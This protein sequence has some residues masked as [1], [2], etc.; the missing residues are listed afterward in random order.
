MIFWFG[1]KKG[2]Y[3]KRFWHICILMAWCLFACSEN[4]TESE[5]APP[6]A[7]GSSQKLV[8]TLEGKVQESL[9]V[10]ARFNENTKVRLVELDDELSQTGSVANGSIDSA[11]N[12][13]VKTDGFT[14]RYA[15]LSVYGNLPFLC[16]DNQNFRLSMVVDLSTDSLANLDYFVHFASA[17]VKMLVKSDKMDFDKAREKAE[18]ETR[19]V[20]ALSAE[21]DNSVEQQAFSMF[22]EAA[23]YNSMDTELLALFDS[24]TNTFAST[25]KPARNDAFVSVAFTAFKAGPNL[26]EIYECPAIVSDSGSVNLPGETVASIQDY[27]QNLWMSILQEKE[28]TE[29]QKGEVH[30]FVES[31]GPANFWM[32]TENY[33]TCDGSWRFVNALEYLNETLTDEEDGKYK[34]FSFAES[35]SGYVYDE[36]SGWR[37]STLFESFFK[38]GCTKHKEGVVYRG[39]VCQNEDWYSEVPES[40]FG[41]V[42]T[43][44]GLPFIDGE[45]VSD[46][47]A[48][49]SGKVVPL[50]PLDTILGKTCLSSNKGE[51]IEIG[52]TQFIC[53]TTWKWVTGVSVD[54][55]VMDTRDSTRYRVIGIGNQRWMGEALRYK[56]QYGYG[57]YTWYE[58]MDLPEETNLDSLKF[59]LPHRGVCPEGWHI[60]SKA[61]WDTLFAFVSKYEKTTTLAKS[62]FVHYWVFEGKYDTIGF[63]VQ[64][65]GRVNLSGRNEKEGQEA[66][67]W[68]A[69]ENFENKYPFYYLVNSKP[70]IQS[71]AFSDPHWGL[72]V[73]CIAD[74]EE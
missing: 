10:K 24:L 29:K 65:N 53:D 9:L 40:Y 1:L 48:C 62:L 45:E 64:P 2:E 11:G 7:S 50:T 14:Q 73:R 74:E 38:S 6:P 43:E 35:S 56:S 13:L 32:Q 15:E 36:V 59:T 72:N 49:D 46:V 47:Y 66:V 60:P 31:V 71:G 39:S 17:R 69:V 41:V 70:D 54:T 3:M 19:E 34:L 18:K 58:A 57:F 26:T 12:F 61:E 21:G 20:F 23:G 25:G 42:C 52:Y 28:C 67:F 51:I 16:S 55:S 37:N 22:L 68:Y 8:A 44:E 27:A 33:Y 63:S 5:L 4:G 30:A